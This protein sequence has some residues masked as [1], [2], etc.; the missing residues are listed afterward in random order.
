MSDSL[1]EIKKGLEM[2]DAKLDTAS[3][4]LDDIERSLLNAVWAE[5]GCEAIKDLN[6]LKFRRRDGEKDEKE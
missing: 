1:D 6:I 4:I 5:G 2:L 3:E